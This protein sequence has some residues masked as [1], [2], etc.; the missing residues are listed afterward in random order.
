MFPLQPYLQQIKSSS[1][2]MSFIL[3]PAKLVSV[4]QNDYAKPTQAG[5]LGLTGCA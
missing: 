5:H 2:L 3:D 4:A 1:H